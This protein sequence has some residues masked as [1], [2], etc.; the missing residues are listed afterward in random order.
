[1]SDKISSRHVSY[2]QAKS[3]VDFMG[4]HIELATGSLRTL[5]ARHTSKR[6]WN[7][8]SSILNSARTGT[9]K[10]ADGWSKYWSDFKNKLKNK[11]NLL[12]KMKRSES[13]TGVKP[14]TK[15]ERRALVILGP[16]FSRKKSSNGHSKTFN[17]RPPEVKLES[18]HD[19]I[20]IDCSN[21]T[22]DNSEQMT[23]I[24]KD[25]S[26][27]SL[28]ACDGSSDDMDVSGIQNLYPKW[29]IEVEKKRAEAD[30]IRAKAEKERVSIAAKNADAALKQADALKKLADATAVQADAI[31]R[32]AISLERNQTDVLAI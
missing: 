31:L 16:Y 32:I 10:T 24:D 23:D 21:T 26:E 8:L 5:E 3:L 18:Y 17:H 1:M 22:S 25:D 4:Q 19:G 7:E 9:K 2:E 29:L 27:D 11:A 6:L 20:G 12:N 13:S 28:D 30:L 15:L 14:L